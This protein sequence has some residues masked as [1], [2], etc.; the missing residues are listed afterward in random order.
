MCAADESGGGH[1]DAVAHRR[2]P[3]ELAGILI[4]IAAAAYLFVQAAPGVRRAVFFDES[5]TNLIAVRPL[6][7]LLHTVIVDR[8]GAPLDFVLAHIAIALHPSVIAPRLVS[9]LF[10]V[11]TV[12]VVYDLGRRLGGVAAGATAAIVVG[13]S[14]LLG[15]Y[16]SMGRMYS[17]LAFVAALAA[18]LFVRALER[19]SGG[20]VTAAAAAA[21]LLPATHPYGGLLAAALA[22]VGAVLWLRSG[23]A[24]RPALPVAAIA[25]AAVPFVYADLRLGRRYA[26]DV[27]SG[28]THLATPGQAVRLVEHAL[29]GFSGGR[30]LF[31]AVFLGL[32]ISGTIVLLR[33]APTFAAAGLLA[34]VAVPLLAL[35]FTKGGETVR[36]GPKHLIF[37]MPF[38]A[39]AIGMAVARATEGRRP[40]IAIAAVVAVA[41][42]AVAAPSRAGDPRIYGSAAN[43]P[44][45]LEP[46]TS[47][48]DREAGPG[49]VLYP[50]SPDVPAVASAL[51]ALRRAQ[52]VPH[53]S[54]RGVRSALSDLSWPVRTVFAA[55]R[56]GPKAFDEAKL[57]SLLFHADE[58][59]VFRYWLVIRLEGSFA[60]TRELLLE[61]SRGFAAV[62]LS[63]RRPTGSAARYVNQKTRNLCRVLLSLDYEC[64]SPPTAP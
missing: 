29:E 55:V 4:T 49:D 40:P 22:L 61:L 42:L 20:R 1:P 48:L 60:D 9:L 19:P 18:D 14:S 35:L 28:G 3:A 44:G 43:Q 12:P 26:V 50:A 2:T 56:I 63:L 57:R 17:L 45:E 39:A 24:I 31:F 27:E 30:G 10:G 37:L 51:T 13:T 21:W 16:A 25:L 59:R 36:L 47:F 5:I 41:V 23:H 34:L 6:P 64:P 15:V 62:S 11:A 32:A 53:G 33:R 7:E 8:G 46:V 58:V 54:P 52:P 38:W